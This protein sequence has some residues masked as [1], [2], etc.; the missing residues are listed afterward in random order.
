MISMQVSKKNKG[1][2]VRPNFWPNSRIIADQETKS[3]VIIGKS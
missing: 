3:Q 1:I 2:K